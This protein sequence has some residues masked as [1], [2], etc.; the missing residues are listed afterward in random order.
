VFNAVCSAFQYTFVVE[1]R[2]LIIFLCESSLCKIFKLN[3]LIYPWLVLWCI[4][5]AQ[6]YCLIQCIFSFL[7]LS[8][9]NITSVRS[10][11]R[12]R[13][14]WIY[15]KCLFT[16]LQSFFVLFNLDVCHCSISESRFIPLQVWINIINW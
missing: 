3:I 7:K 9:L 5:I 4:F 13:K 10:H 16:I 15:R 2:L 6:L 8:Y 1:F 14:F 11:M 12:L